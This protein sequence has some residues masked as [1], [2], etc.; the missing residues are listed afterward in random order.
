MPP[1]ALPLGSGQCVRMSPHTIGNWGRLV[2]VHLD[3]QGISLSLLSPEC[4]LMP[5]LE[6]TVAPSVES[7]GPIPSQL[8]QTRCTTIFSSDEIG[9]WQAGNERGIRAGALLLR[10]V[11]LL[12]QIYQSAQAGTVGSPF[13]FGLTIAEALLSKVITY[14]VE[15]QAPAQLFER[16]RVV[17]M[18]LHVGVIY[19]ECQ[20]PAFHKYIF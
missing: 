12:P 13:W 11:F 10:I 15:L 1:Y 8:P 3:V 2:R 5:R 7:C 9:S 20:I 19:T 14:T 18:R 4:A 16:R 6:I 17:L